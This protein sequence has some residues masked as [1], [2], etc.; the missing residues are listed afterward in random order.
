MPRG[1]TLRNLWGDELTNGSR[2]ALAMQAGIAV[3]LQRERSA[4][5]QSSEQNF[6]RL[7]DV[8]AN[9]GELPRIL[10][11]IALRRADRR[12]PFPLRMLSSAFRNALMRTARGPRRRARHT[13]PRGERN[14]HGCAT[15][16]TI[17]GNGTPR[18]RW[19][20]DQS[21]SRLIGT[22]ERHYGRRTS[23]FSPS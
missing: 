17:T 4:Q 18:R 13:S 14:S 22:R 20:R 12:G 7:L 8:C 19:P 9:C 11:R 3:A 21:R 6:A 16:T 1:C 2:P 10:H 23:A 5:T 15:L